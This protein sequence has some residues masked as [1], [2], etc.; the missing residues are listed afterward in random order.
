MLDSCINS[1][2]YRIFHVDHDLLL[3]RQCLKIPFLMLNIQKRKDK[4]M[5]SLLKLPDYKLVL[6]VDAQNVLVFLDWFVCL[7]VLRISIQY[8]QNAI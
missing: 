6:E 8:N 7:S 2:L 4:F 1:A 3:L 5:N